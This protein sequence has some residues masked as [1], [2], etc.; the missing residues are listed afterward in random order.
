[1]KSEEVED[2]TIEIE[3]CLYIFNVGAKKVGGSFSCY[4]PA[5]ANS[6]YEIAG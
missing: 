3:K 4:I 1:M 2:N 6:N 5:T